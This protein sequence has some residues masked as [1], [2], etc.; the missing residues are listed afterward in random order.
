MLTSL[1]G[2]TDCTDETLE[3]SEPLHEEQSEGEHASRTGDE[4]FGDD[5]TSETED[6]DTEN[7]SDSDISEFLTSE[8]DDF[9][10]LD[11]SD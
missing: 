8:S 11:I 3:E 10:D 1:S 5:E 6:T 7:I 9:T 4:C 2:S